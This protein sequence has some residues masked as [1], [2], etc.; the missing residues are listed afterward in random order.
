MNTPQAF[1]QTLASYKTG[2]Y[3]ALYQSEAA[4]HELTYNTGDWLYQCFATLYLYNQGELAALYGD[5]YER[6]NEEFMQFCCKCLLAFTKTA[7]YAHMPKT[8]GFCAFCINHDE[9]I[10]AAENR[11]RALL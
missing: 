4:I 6:W 8:E 3:A 11:M 10:S 9:D 5:N 2:P 1:E 7:T